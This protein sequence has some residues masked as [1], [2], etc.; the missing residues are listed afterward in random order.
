MKKSIA[1]HDVNTGHLRLPCLE[2]IKLDT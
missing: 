2:E 1:M